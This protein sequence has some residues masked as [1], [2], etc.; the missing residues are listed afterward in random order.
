MIKTQVPFHEPGNLSDEQ[1][2][3]KSGDS[4]SQCSGK[5]EVGRAGRSGGTVGN[6]SFARPA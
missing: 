3:Y 5:R 4:L 1:A 2:I 6:I